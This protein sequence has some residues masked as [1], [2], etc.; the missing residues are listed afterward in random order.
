[1]KPI[2]D[3]SKLYKPETPYENAHSRPRSTPPPTPREVKPLSPLKNPNP[4]LLIS[5]WKNDYDR[6]KRIK[7]SFSI[8]IWSCLCLIAP[9][10]S[11][12]DGFRELGLHREVF[13]ELWVGVEHLVMEIDSE[14]SSSSS[15]PMEMETEEPIVS[16]VF[17]F[18]FVL[19]VYV[20]SSWTLNWLQL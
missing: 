12:F 14:T 19:Y 20:E 7:R 13:R 9:L 16:G 6:N 11:Y 17:T 8:D 1:M 3:S 15:K 5:H 2:V 18:L 10:S 4:L